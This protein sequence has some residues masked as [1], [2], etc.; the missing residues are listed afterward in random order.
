MATA[1]APDQGWAARVAMSRAWKM[2]GRQD[3]HFSPKGLKRGRGG[4]LEFMMDRR[5]TPATVIRAPI[6]REGIRLRPSKP[7]RAPAQNKKP[8]VK[9]GLLHHGVSTCANTM[10]WS[11]FR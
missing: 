11:Y 8:G 6:Y 5:A 2:M 7:G 3:V 10:L 4:G 9:P 1:I